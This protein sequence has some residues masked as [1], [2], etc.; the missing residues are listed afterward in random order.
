M[1]SQLVLGPTVENMLGEYAKIH[2]LADRPQ[3]IWRIE[4]GGDGVV[5]HNLHAT[6][7]VGRAVIEFLRARQAPHLRLSRPG[8]MDPRSCPQL[9]GPDHVS[10]GDRLSVRPARGR[11]E[12][13]RHRAPRLVHR[14]A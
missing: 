9:P 14:I 8:A 12:F 5:I 2:W 4:L 1:V 6:D 13:D 7:R 3:G 10:S 11:L